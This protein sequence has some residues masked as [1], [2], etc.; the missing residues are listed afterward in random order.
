[1]NVGS[2]SSRQPPRRNARGVRVRADF[3]RSK[4][5]SKLFSTF[6]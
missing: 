5:L 1:M 6:W 3:P 4:Y 2:A